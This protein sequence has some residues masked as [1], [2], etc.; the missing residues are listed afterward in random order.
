[1]PAPLLLSSYLHCEWLALDEIE[2]PRILGKVKRYKNKRLSMGLLPHAGSTVDGE[3][4]V[5]D[6]DEDLFNMDYVEVDRVLDM[7]MV[8]AVTGREIKSRSEIAAMKRR[9]AAAA[10]DPKR[11]SAK[12]KKGSRVS[13]VTGGS[14]RPQSSEEDDEDSEGSTEEDEEEGQSGAAAVVDNG[15]LCEEEVEEENRVTYYLVKWR[16]LSYEDA[17]WELAQDVDPLK[18]K[19]YLRWRT[20]PPVAQRRRV[21]RPESSQWSKMESSDRC[22]KNANSLRDYQLEGVN[23]LSFCWYN[24]RNCILADEMGLGKTV[25]SIAF[26][27]EVMRFGVRGPYLIIVP[28]STLGNWQREFENWTDM[29]VIVYHGR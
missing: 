19:E 25:Q 12:R 14:G 22:Y 20:P 23:W 6:E 29:N 11:N 24:E 17:T 27:L 28:L 26:L 1:M 9:A 5:E 2:D 10:K 3:E 15:P 7:K 21:P 18:V 4:V 13:A 16:S 8:C